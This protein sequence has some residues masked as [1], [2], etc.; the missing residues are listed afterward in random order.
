MNDRRVVY[1]WGKTSEV[2]EIVRRVKGLTGE[3]SR[4]NHALNGSPSHFLHSS[5]NIRL[6]GPPLKGKQCGELGFRI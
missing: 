2:C 4:K 1:I 3:A 5:E 6:L